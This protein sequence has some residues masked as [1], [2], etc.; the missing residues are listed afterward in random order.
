[1]AILR[2]DSS[3]GLAMHQ[4]LHRC[5]TRT[6]VL[7]LL[8]AALVFRALI[9]AG[10][11]P[12]QDENGRM[13]MELCAGFTTKSVI[14]DLGAGLDDAPTPGSALFEHSPCGFTAAALSAPPPDAP[15]VFASLAPE[16]PLPAADVPVDAAYTV[17]RT[18]SPRGP[19][20]S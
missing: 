12:T 1:M 10:F 17:H 5:L 3:L 15:P 9:P 18:Q 4:F 19:P 8:M 16:A 11:M 7:G 13:V 14:V 20:L 2:R 6:P